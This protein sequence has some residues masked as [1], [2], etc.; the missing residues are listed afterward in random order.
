[1]STWAGLSWRLQ[2]FHDLEGISLVEADARTGHDNAEP[3]SFFIGEE[4]AHSEPGFV[5]SASGGL[6]LVFRS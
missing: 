6:G 2:V 5:A 4:S 1:M 3:G